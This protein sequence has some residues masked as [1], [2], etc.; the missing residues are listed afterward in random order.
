MERF[1]NMEHMNFLCSLKTREMHGCFQ[2]HKVILFYVWSTPGDK[3]RIP[4]TFSLLE[5]GN[6][7]RHIS[8]I[9]TA[10]F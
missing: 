2:G 9:R 10:K 4:M 1:K 7:V 3:Y 5:S 8:K 6:L